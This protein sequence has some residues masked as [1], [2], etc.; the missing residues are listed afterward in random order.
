MSEAPSPEQFALTQFSK[1]LVPGSVKQ[2]M[3]GAGARSADL[4][5]V[6]ISQL[7]VMPNFN[8]REQGPRLEAHI[9]WLADSM[10]AEGYYPNSA[11]DVYVANEGGGKEIIYV[12]DGHCRLAAVKLAIAEGA[13]IDALPAIIVSKG[14]SMEDLNVRILRRAS[15]LP[16]LPLEQGIPC[17]RLSN[18]G[19]D[20]AMI[21]ERTGFSAQKVD[22]LLLLMAAPAD[23][24]QMVR[25]K[26]V[27]AKEAVHQLKEN[28]SSA[29]QTL[30][31]M[32]DTAKARGH[33]AVTARDRPGRDAEYVAHKNASSMIDAL[34]AVMDDPGFASLSPGVRD[35]VEKLVGPNSPVSRLIHGNG[36]QRSLGLGGNQLN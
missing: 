7:H 12:V 22:E 9:R 16:L 3:Q 34:R 19:W 23:V 4:Y 24:R 20:T 18:F 15:G 17:K 35:R 6:P 33:K 1:V 27:T 2:A 29:V 28:G 30:L 36:F 10:K 8:V 5:K 11:L 26:K 13:E 21:A 31:A 32:Q 25:D 14:T